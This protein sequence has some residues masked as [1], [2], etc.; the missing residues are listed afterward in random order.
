MTAQYR[1]F[2]GYPLQEDSPFDCCPGCG[3]RITPWNT[4][5]VMPALPRF[6][7]TT[8]ETVRE[9]AV[10]LAKHHRELA[11]QLALTLEA[12]NTRSTDE[13]LGPGPLCL[14]G[15]RV[16]LTRALASGEEGLTSP[17]AESL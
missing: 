14:V 3:E 13:T 15:L 1:H 5:E 17:Q 8:D 12:G 7:V 11:A 10:W 6:P 9:L 4:Q 2:C 16:H